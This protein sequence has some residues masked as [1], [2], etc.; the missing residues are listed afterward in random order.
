MLGVERLRIQGTA[1]PPPP[2]LFAFLG[3]CFVWG[4]VK[5]A[6]VGAKKTHDLGGSIILAPLFEELQYRGAVERGV[7]KIGG[8][9]AI[10]SEQARIATA[11]F[12]G[13]GHPGLEVDAAVGGY[14]Y[15]KAWDAHGFLGAVAAHAAHNLGCFAGGV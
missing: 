5:A 14:V 7:V 15:S 11:I 4:A 6:A 10:S 1:G 3:A 8:Q 2:S 9:G 12:F 13:L